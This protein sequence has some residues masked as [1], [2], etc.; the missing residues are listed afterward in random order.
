MC[1]N[2]KSSLGYLV[3]AMVLVILDQFAIVKSKLGL[4]FEWGE[5]LAT[6]I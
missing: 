1:P 4:K 6:V 2:S 5:Q 3:K